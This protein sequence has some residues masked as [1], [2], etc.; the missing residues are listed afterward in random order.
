MSYGCG[1]SSC[2]TCYPFT[3]RC[4]VCATDFPEPVPNGQPVPVCTHCG[5]DENDLDTADLSSAT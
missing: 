5:F 1:A 2:K 3:Y 4:E